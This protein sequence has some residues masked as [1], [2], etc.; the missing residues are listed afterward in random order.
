MNHQG[1]YCRYSLCDL[2]VIFV[3]FSFLIVDLTLIDLIFSKR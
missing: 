1:Y 2:A 3:P